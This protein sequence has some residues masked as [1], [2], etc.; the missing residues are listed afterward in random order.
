MVLSTNSHDVQDPR[1][2]VLHKNKVRFLCSVLL[3]DPLYERSILMT[4]Q[5]EPKKARL[6]RPY[7]GRRSMQG[8]TNGE[9]G[10]IEQKELAAGVGIKS[11]AVS[12]W[13]NG[14]TRPDIALLPLICQVLEVSLDELFDIKKED[15]ESTVNEMPGI[16][17]TKA[18][19]TEDDILLEG[20]HQLSE[21]HRSVVSSLV[22]KLCDLKR[23]LCRL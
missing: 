9:A 6:D 14:R 16:T 18:P 13:E 7:A 2:S 8:S 19:V 20:Y 5:N 23:S 3:N 4:E 15:P 17:M 22:R 21:G 1:I 12:N 11:N 10:G